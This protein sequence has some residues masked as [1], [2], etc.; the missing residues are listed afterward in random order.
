MVSRHLDI[1][2][3]KIINELDTNA[4]QSY[5][6]IA[7]RVGLTKDTVQYRIRKLEKEGVIEGYYTVI[8]TAKLGYAFYRVCLKF[9]NLSME[10]ENE[11]IEHLKAH[12]A[13]GWISTFNGRWDMIIAIWARDI[14]DFEDI[15]SRLFNKYEQH[16]Q[17][18]AISTVIYIYHFKNKAITDSKDESGVILGG[19]IKK[20]DINRIDFKILSLLADNAR[21]PLMGIGGKLNL[22]A[23]AVKSRIRR[24]LKQGIILGFRAKLNEKI[25]GFYHY[26]IFL[27]L[28]NFTKEK[29]RLL[30]H[31]LKNSPYVIYIT[32]AVGIAELEFEILVKKIEEFYNLINNIRCKLGEDVLKG[33]ESVLVYEEKHIRYLP[34]YW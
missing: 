19:K 26:K 25:L 18:K 33:Y 7:K 23:N 9:R 15:L 12:A 28:Q 1:K 11:L 13:V 22:S 3:R 16:I 27:H 10:K 6:Q 24:L 17:E 4:R 34:L 31:L 8:N 32:K 2:D 21:I 20:T 30:I 14:I 5:S 29:E